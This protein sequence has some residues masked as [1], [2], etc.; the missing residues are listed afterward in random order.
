MMRNVQNCA[1]LRQGG[2]ACSSVPSVP[3][4]LLLAALNINHARV[5]AS[6]KSPVP[7]VVAR[8]G[9][10]RSIS[11]QI[12]SAAQGEPRNR[13]ASPIS[14]LSN[15]K[16]KMLCFDFRASELAGHIARVEDY[17]P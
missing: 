5:W 14:A 16:K 15:P 9:F 10:L 3:P 8:A 4:T 17:P 6:G 2:Y 7:G 1:D 13:R 11:R 12:S